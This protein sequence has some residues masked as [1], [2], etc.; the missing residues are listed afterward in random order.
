[1]LTALKTPSRQLAGVLSLGARKQWPYVCDLVI[2]LG[3]RQF[4]LEDPFHPSPPLVDT[5]TLLPS[6]FHVFGLCHGQCSAASEANI[7]T[8]CQA[9]GV[10]TAAA[11]ANKASI[12]T[13]NTAGQL[14]AVLLTSLDS[15]IRVQSLVSVP[16]P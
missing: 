3:G 14:K 5:W 6:I 11:L 8:A 2:C 10:S 9:S 13:W 12:P 1:A 7:L 16:K 15:L 4:L